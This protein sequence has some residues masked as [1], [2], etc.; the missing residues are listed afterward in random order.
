MK[1][2]DKSPEPA[3]KAKRGNAFR[4]RR[5]PADGELYRQ[6]LDFEPS[7]P[8]IRAEEE[9]ES[10]RRGFRRATTVVVLL[11]LTALGYVAVKET[12]WANPSFSLRH[13]YVHT[14]GMLTPTEIAYATGLTEGTNL[15]TADL[16]AVRGRLMSLPAIKGVTVQRDFAGRMDVTVQQRQPVAW[17]RIERLGWIPKKS[18]AGLLVD[19]EGAAIPCVHMMDAYD[20]LPEISDDSIEQVVPG[21]VLKGEQFTAALNLLR[22]LSERQS[23]GGDAVRSVTVKNACALEAVL[24]S[25]LKA[26]FAWDDL[27]TEL[28]RF[29]LIVA[30]A[31]RRK[32]HLMTVNLMAET[33]LP[34]TF[35]P[36]A[37]EGAP[38]AAVPI[39]RP[40]SRTSATK[41][42]SSPTR[43]TRR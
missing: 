3:K 29:D 33:N 30:E 8:K 42:S 43:R 15:L 19:A 4:P 24:G 10:R 37:K 23:L 18:G 27:E 34:I 12:V 2:K 26:T 38:P 41:S 9:E 11:L 35:R 1:K 40:A 32:W 28:K 20:G 17:V 16:G 25:G 31:Q 13:V 21:A 39:A 22:R 5:K 14:S 7:T 36:V 6:P